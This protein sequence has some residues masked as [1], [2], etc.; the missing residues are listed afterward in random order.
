[1]KVELLVNLKVKSGQI[2]SA[3]SIFSDEN[4]PIPDFIMRRVGRKMARVL[5]DKKKIEAPPNKTGG[6]ST[7]SATGK[8]GKPETTFKT[9]TAEKP[10]PVKEKK[11]KKVLLKKETPPEG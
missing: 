3:G 6:V 4:G 8:I 11:E 10:V 7:L 1:M 5:S 2:I 9:R